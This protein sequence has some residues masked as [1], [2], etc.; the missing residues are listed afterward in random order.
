MMRGDAAARPDS[1][2]RL[3]RL[4]VCRQPSGEAVDRR[5]ESQ[6]ACSECPGCTRRRL[7]R[8]MRGVRPCEDHC[9]DG[10]DAY[11][12]RD[13][14]KA[15]RARRSEHRPMSPRGLRH[16]SADPIAGAFERGG[17]PSERRGR[18]ARDASGVGDEERVLAERPLS[19]DARSLAPAWAPG[20][21]AARAC[22]P[23]V[24]S[25]SGAMAADSMSAGTRSDPAKL[26]GA[27]D[28]V[29]V[30][31]G[32]GRALALE[33]RHWRALAVPSMTCPCWS[34]ICS[35]RSLPPVRYQSMRSTVVNYG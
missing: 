1:W 34:S 11:Q 13:G 5:A 2:R 33:R 27:S 19:A 29:S 6:L 30:A 15:S 20:A 18:A 35:R 8:R 4:I 22:S 17:H 24:E 32:A 21:P 31:S 16:P 25:P 10:D 12:G 14:Q 3:D 26:F 9:R 28:L 7:G 23:S